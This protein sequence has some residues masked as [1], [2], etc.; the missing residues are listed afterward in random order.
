MR[1]FLF[2][3]SA[4]FLSGCATLNSQ[5]S[6]DEVKNTIEE[7]TGQKLVWNQE[8]S[9]DG[10]VKKQ[11][12][13]LLRGSLTVDDALKISLLN[14]PTLQAEYEELGVAQSELVQAGLLQNPVL[15]FERRFRGKAAE[16]DISQNFLSLFLIPLRTKAASAELE[17]EIKKVTQLVLNHTTEV[18]SAFYSLQAEQQS[19]EMRESV[20]KA[21]NA[22]YEAARALR[23]AGN[24]TLLEVQNEANMLAQAKVE[25]A[26]ASV[27][28]LEEREHL[29]V[30]LGAW[31][32]NTGWRIE[33][34]LPN[35]PNEEVTLPG[36]E[37][38]AISHRLDLAAA[39]NEL[40]SVAAKVGIARYE[41]L[42]PDLT[43]TGH[44]ERE[45]EGTITRGPSVVF[46]VPLFNWG[47]AASAQGNAL[48]RQSL[49]R[50]EAMAIE[51]R[52]KV[53]VAYGRMKAARMRAEYFYKEVLP[54]QKKTLEQTELF[55]N[56]MFVGVF[57]LL[58]AKQA[59]ITAGQS[60]IETLKEY[61]LR[62]TELEQAVGGSFKG[63]STS[64]EIPISGA[65]PQVEIE[66]PSNGHQHHHGN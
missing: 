23:E 7:R 10:D 35:L 58:Q 30:L 55:Y 66:S 39:K 44:Y 63:L 20:V 52:S 33:N 51:L 46:P 47:K 5:E 3:T 57:Q 60:Y 45:P 41:A 4:F 50:Y 40:E 34:R 15:S 16:A 27:R 29:N 9:E 26:Q 37:S 43:L 2:F 1:K 24:T 6:F 18:T 14:N 65:I 32:N 17:A 25:L 62:R 12:A 22:S 11:I 59:Q 31:G 19:L 53:R 54:L 38:F 36:L 8:G 64:N 48:F 49:R 13:E 28:V 61:W 42:I 56:G 21:L